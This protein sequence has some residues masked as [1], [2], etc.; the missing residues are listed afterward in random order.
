[1]D[2]QL[3]G[4]LAFVTAGAQGIGGAIANLLA[5]EGASVIVADQD[6]A[7]LRENGRAWRATCAADLST[8]AGM[9]KA[10]AYVLQTFG[11][12]PDILINNL[13][14]ADPVPFEQISD[15]RWVRSLNINLLGCVRTCR[16]LVPRMAALGSAAVV[17]IGSDLGKQP[18]PDVIDY[19]LF[20]IGVL[21]LTKSL[22]KAYANAV[23]FLAS[24]L[25]KF[26]TGANLDLGGTLRGL[27]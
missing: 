12:A 17:N 13:G 27:I 5:Q 2:Y 7:A 19:G 22:A 9:D 14:V 24:P 18:E 1:M 6:E 25:A 20:K 23:V 8:A 16:A 15:E 10:V 21:H 26:I 3:K 11:R 4:K